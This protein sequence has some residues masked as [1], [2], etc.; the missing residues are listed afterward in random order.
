MSVSRVCL[1]GT[2]GKCEVFE[3]RVKEGGIDRLDFPEL[4]DR[5]VVAKYT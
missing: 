5:R 3:I 4:P 2:V 1:Y